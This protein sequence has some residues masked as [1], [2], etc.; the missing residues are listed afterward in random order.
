MLVPIDTIAGDHA[1][2]VAEQLR[3]ALDAYRETLLADRRNLFEQ[4]RLVDIARKVVGV[5]SVG[6]RSWVL[7]FMGARTDDPL[8]LQAKEAE[9]SVLEPYSKA[10]QFTT[11][12]ERVVVGQ[13]MMQATSDIFLGWTGAKS[14]VSGREFY[15]RQFADTKFSAAIETMVPEGFTA[16][17]SLCA[18]TLARAHARTGDRYAIAGYLGK[19]DAFE[20]ALA[21]FAE[22]YADQNALDYAALQESVASGRI[23]AE[24]GV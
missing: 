11:S 22:L 16:Y 1:E 21:T 17:A 8:L 4:Y 10:S 18:R 6:T 2:L 13:R 7:L 23:K 3:A 5:G 24:V 19:T 15:F 20:V 12:A 14:N 9:P